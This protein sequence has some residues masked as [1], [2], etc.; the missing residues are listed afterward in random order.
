M[1]LLGRN[2]YCRKTVLGDA[3][4]QANNAR[5]LGRR[6]I[7]GVFKLEAVLQSTFTGTPYRPKF[8][9]SDGR[10]QQIKAL[11]KV[12]KDTIIGRYSSYCL[13]YY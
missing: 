8:R 7:Q 9:S 3:L 12:A 13:K 11:H 1:I 4:N 10:Q 5:Q 2:I 6:L